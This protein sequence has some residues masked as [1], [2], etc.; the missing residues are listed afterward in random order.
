MVGA[1]SSAGAAFQSSW[2]VVVVLSLNPPIEC[3]LGAAVIEEAFNGHFDNHHA[4]LLIR[5][6]GRIDVIDF[7][8]AAVDAQNRGAVG[9][10]RVGGG[11]G[12]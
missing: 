3:G 4:F 11:P 1:R 2:L 12:R 5:M 7:D 9:P 6:L 8:I 10:I